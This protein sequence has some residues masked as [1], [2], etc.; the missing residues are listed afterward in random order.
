[1][2]STFAEEYQIAEADRQ[3]ATLTSEGYNKT[4]NYLQEILAGVKKGIESYTDADTDSEEY[5]SSLTQD[6]VEY[7]GGL[8]LVKGGKTVADQYYSSHQK[9]SGDMSRANAKAIL[10]K[11]NAIIK[12]YEDKNQKVGVILQD[13]TEKRN[14]AATT[15]SK[16]LDKLYDVYK[17]V[18]QF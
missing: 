13:A 18:A 6:E 14:I 11:L 16:I 15:L 8:R 2:F 10:S 4:L 1:M 17:L 9:T 5:L 3:A 12:T 7:L